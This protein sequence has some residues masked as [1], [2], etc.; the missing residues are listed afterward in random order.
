MAGWAVEHPA[1]SSG[2]G[3]RGRDRRQFSKPRLHV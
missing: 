3:G 1:G 2:S